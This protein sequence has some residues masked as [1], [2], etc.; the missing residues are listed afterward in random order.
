MCQKLNSTKRFFVLLNHPAPL[1]KP[2]LLRVLRN[3][4]EAIQAYEQTRNTFFLSKPQ[5][6]TLGVE[7]PPECKAYLLPVDIPRDWLLH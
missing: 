3:T 2:L 4:P 6:S 5:I 7:P 1:Q